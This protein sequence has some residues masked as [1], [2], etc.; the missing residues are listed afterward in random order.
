MKIITLEMPEK[1]S[2]ND[3]ADAMGVGDEQIALHAV[4]RP[5]IEPIDWRGDPYCGDK[6]CTTTSHAKMKVWAEILTY[7]ES[8]LR[9]ELIR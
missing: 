2:D 1:F 7:I 9:R 5:G 8:A 6:F 3:I 4:M